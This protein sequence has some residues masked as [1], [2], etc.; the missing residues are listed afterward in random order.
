M[1]NINTL[2]FGAIT[3]YVGS[4][5]LLGAGLVAISAMT[6]SACSDK[7]ATSKSGQALVSV[8]GTEITVSQ[9]NDELQRSTISLSPNEQQAAAK[10]MLDSLVDRQLIINAAMKD[11]VDRDPQVVRAVE[12]AKAVLIAQSYMQKKLNASFKPAATEINGYYSNNPQFFSNRKQFELHQLVFSDN[13]PADTKAVVDGAKTLDEVAGYLDAHRIRYARN[14]ISRT[15]ADFSKEI[16]AN[17]MSM[18][19]GQLFL[20]REGQQY[21]LNVIA[22]VQEAP[23]SLE[24]ASPQIEQF[25]IAGKNKVSFTE[26]VARLRAVARIEYLNKSVA[27]GASTTVSPPVTAS[28]ESEVL[29]R[30]VAGLK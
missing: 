26:E 16:S 9:L 4:A 2:V 12:R 1:N 8:E 7:V 20:V 6:L 28:A 24:V 3:H 10:R 22:N 23:V 30:G 27:G 19:K 21:V 13:V 25:L 18:P 11:G 5:R 15:T 17:L 14:R 29:A